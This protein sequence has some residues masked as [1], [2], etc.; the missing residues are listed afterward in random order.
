MQMMYS[1]CPNWTPT[2]S[3][4]AGTTSPGLNHLETPSDNCT[5]LTAPPPALT[6]NAPQRHAQQCAITQHGIKK[7]KQTKNTGHHARPMRASATAPPRTGADTST[8]DGMAAMLRAGS[9]CIHACMQPL[10][11]MD[12]CKRHARVDVTYVSMAFVQGQGAVKVM[13][14]CLGE[15]CTW[16]AC[17]KWCTKRCHVMHARHSLVSLGCPTPNHA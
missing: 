2:T 13:L 5:P 15:V 4:I 14:P 10:P 7:N 6:D 17:T 12:T 11:C 1:P 8:S 16:H 3:G 9:G